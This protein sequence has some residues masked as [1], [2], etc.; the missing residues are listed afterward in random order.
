MYKN[1]TLKDSKR[2][3]KNESPQN[4]IAI[5]YYILFIL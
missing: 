2:E 4:V 1:E 3:E 5:F